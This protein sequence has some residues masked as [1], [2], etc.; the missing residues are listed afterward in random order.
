MLHCCFDAQSILV[1]LIVSFLSLLYAAKNETFAAYYYII[2]YKCC[3]EVS[4]KDIKEVMTKHTAAPR[5][6]NANEIYA[7]KN[8]LLEY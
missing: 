1:S 8:K 5:K 4:I 7:L 6:R 2:A 3:K